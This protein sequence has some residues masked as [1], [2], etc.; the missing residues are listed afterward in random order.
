MATPGAGLA[1]HSDVFISYCHKDNAPFGEGDK[2]WVSDF[3]RD[4]ATRVEAYLGRP[5]RIWRDA[6]LGGEDLFSDEITLR[7]ESAVVLVSVVSPAYLASDWCRREVTGFA[8]AARRSGG[9]QVGTKAR[10]VKVLKTRVDR[11]EQIRL[12][13]VL[14]D[15]LGFEFYKVDP[16]SE[17]VRELFLHPDPEVRREYWTRIDDV[18]Q[19]I[20]A[21]VTR[22]QA[23]RAA[24]AGAAPPAGSGEL[25]YL[26]E[27]TSD[28]Q[29]ERD[30]LRRELEDRGYQIAPSRPLPVYV[31]GFEKAVRA[32]L[33]QARL[34]IHVF[35]ARYGLIP[36]GTD[37]SAVALQSQ[38][39]AERALPRVLWI[40]PGV[41]PREDRQSQ[42]LEGLRNAP[43]GHNGFD[44]LDAAPADRVKSLVLDKLRTKAPAPPAA[45][46]L[47]GGPASIYLMCD[48]RDAEAVGPLRD[49]LLGL[50][51]EVMLPLL[52]GEPAQIDADH[53]DTLRT[54][55]AVLIYWG[56]A[57]QFWLRTKQRDLVRARGLGRARPFTAVSIFAAAPSTAA[58]TA[59][60][61]NEAIVIC[62]FDPFTPQSLAAFVTALGS[63]R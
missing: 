56:A 24:P 22:V 38:M 48:G 33:E 27:T 30:A 10:V 15:V 47:T 31:E 42:F 39:A 52:E 1:D 16:E 36:E 20:A 46:A 57:D 44:L 4:L 53:Q 7:L 5:G 35:G 11:H 51:H 6:K 13:P 21:L 62:Q 63:A 8:D 29:G 45:P 43:G 54:C 9:L 55:D 19:S 50:G 40:P 37:R 26:A 41:Q 58:K 3:H 60:R 59:L 23:E 28:V 17:R 32:E 18:A 34:S 2:R 12:A 25:I 49:H 14:D 61:S